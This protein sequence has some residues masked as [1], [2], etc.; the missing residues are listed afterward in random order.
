[1]S[2]QALFTGTDAEGVEYLLTVYRDDLA[3]TRTIAVRDPVSRRWGPPA[4][5]APVPLETEARS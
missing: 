3:V 1:V 5:L 2:D 4:V